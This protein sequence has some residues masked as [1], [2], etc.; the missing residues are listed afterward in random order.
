[1][2][3]ARSNLTQARLR[4]LLCYDPESGVFTNRV[5][6]CGRAKA[7]DVA[8]T[9]GHCGYLV[10]T[11]DRVQHSCH[12]L[13]WLYIHGEHPEALIDHIDGNPANN[14][15]SNLRLASGRINSE[16]R[17]GAY[18]NSKTGLLGVSS[19]GHKYRASIGVAGEVRVLGY[20]RCPQEA[21]QAYIKAKRELH[22]GC[23]I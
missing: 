12:R 2:A 4:E 10:V 20:F 23:T 16:N 8:G 7:G 15:I 13:A 21:H 3:S 22:E 19:H 6:R 18:I 14:Q 5:T 11:L 9:P 1:M 17:R